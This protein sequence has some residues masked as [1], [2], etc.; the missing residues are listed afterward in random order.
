MA[1]GLNG[2]MEVSAFLIGERAKYKRID[3]PEFKMLWNNLAEMYSRHL[4]IITNSYWWL[5]G[6][7]TQ[8]LYLLLW[9]ECL[10][11]SKNVYAEILI[12]NIMVL[13]SN[14]FRKWIDHERRALSKDTS[15]L[16]G[17]MQAC[18]PPLV[19]SMWGH[20]KKAAACKPG[21]GPS[22]HNESPCTSVC[23]S[24]P[25]KDVPFTK[26]WERNVC[27]LSHAVCGILLQQP[28]LTK[29]YVLTNSGLITTPFAFYHYETHFLHSFI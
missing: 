2:S 25:P 4:T 7:Q 20:S 9:T 15:A 14:D 29:T 3:N 26:L 22:P 24:Q 16:T 18:P 13:G 27:C 21:R 23:I 11:P 12:L 6:L 8:E 17:N 10:C 5:T 19:S 1:S 28:K